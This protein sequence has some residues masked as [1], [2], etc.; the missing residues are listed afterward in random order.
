MTWSEGGLR[1]RKCDG[2]GS[3]DFRLGGPPSDMA[4]VAIERKI[5]RVYYIR[6]IV[7]KDKG[8]V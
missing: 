4:D 6:K 7:W 5:E 8:G 2:K 1:C 3:L